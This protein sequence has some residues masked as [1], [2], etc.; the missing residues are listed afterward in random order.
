M[1]QRRIRIG[2]D[3][4]GTFTD[5]VAFDEDSG[6]LVTTKTPSTP[7]NPADGFITGVAQGARPDGRDRDGHHGGLPRHDRRDQQAARGQ[8]RGARA[9]SPPRATSSCSRSP[10]RRCPTATATP[11]SGSSP[12]AS[13]PADRV[14]TVGGRM[15][16]EGNEIRPFDEDG[17]RGRRPLVPRP[18][19]HHDRRLL[20]ALLRQRHPRAGDARGAAPR[21]PRGRRVDQRARCCASTASTSA[22]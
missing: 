17:R 10:G 5:V 18:R 13:S 1:A 7:S 8:G 20:P 12:R 4:G 14:R 6:E 9:S 16:F 19:H 22:R 15:D 3:T 2:I 11:T 21:A